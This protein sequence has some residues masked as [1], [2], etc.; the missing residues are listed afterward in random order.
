MNHIKRDGFILKYLI[1]GQGNPALVIG[2]VDY[3]PQTFSPNLRKHLQLI[4]TD[5]RGF[6]KATEP[7]DQSDYTLDKIVDDIEALRVHLK[8]KKMILIGHSGHAHMAA[9]YAKKYSEFVSH[10]ILIGI[11]PLENHEAANIYFDEMAS[12][13][14]KALL[15]KNLMHMQNDFVGRMLSFG[16]MLWYQYDYDASHLWEKVHVNADIVDYLWSQVFR[17]ADLKEGLETL[18]MPID[19]FLGRYDFFNPPHL[20]EAIKLQFP[21]LR[22]HIFEKSGHTPQLGESENF[23][24]ELLRTL[25]ISLEG[26]IQSHEKYIKSGT[27]NLWTEYLGEQ[28]NECV[29]LISGAG[30]S[31]KFW[32]DRFCSILVN[33]GYFV[34]RFDHR[35]QNMSD[36]V[37]W[38]VHP[39][40]VRDLA[41][42]AIHILD[43]YHI[44][45]AHVVGHSMGGTIAQL[46]AI[47]HP[48][49]LLSFTSMSVSTVGKI[50]SPPQDVMDV[51][52]ENQPTQNYE[53]DLVGF[54]RSWEIL[55]GSFELDEDLATAYTK[56]LYDRTKHPVGVAWNHIRCQ[57]SLGDIMDGLK[58]NTVPGLFIHGEN[59]PLMPIEGGIETFEST[60]NAKMVKNPGMGHMFFN[61]S[62]ESRIADDLIKHFK[63]AISTNN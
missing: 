38:A 1:E 44:K 20:W 41:E 33:A 45:K 40:S 3:Y 13:E 60:G 46:L 56:D 48:D 34:I 57:D 25:S 39:Y 42:D 43:A 8:L 9:A 62:L 26:K 10:L 7:Y 37:N 35:D 14:R 50:T 63:A 12:P 22:L 61:H 15:A 30:A 16:P 58:N 24:R 47:N 36:G 29:L 52:M 59:D 21:E 18:N 23:D 54:M 28:K 2:S 11:S 31:A 4:F 17:H 5:H 32:S 27:L 51:L 49:R 6:A 53:Q 55:N 19:I